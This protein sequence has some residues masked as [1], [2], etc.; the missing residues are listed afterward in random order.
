[1]SEMSVL[2]LRSSRNPMLAL[3]MRPKTMRG[4]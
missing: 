3:V 1:M 2:L 4:V